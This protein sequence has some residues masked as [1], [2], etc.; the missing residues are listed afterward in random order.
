M[1]D[2]AR[3]NAVAAAVTRK[4]CMMWTCHSHR[5]QAALQLG[6]PLA[7]QCSVLAR[8]PVLGAH[9]RSLTE[10]SDALW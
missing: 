6:L 7:F 2:R 4:M 3:P 1:H 10:T 5:G 9:H 8:P